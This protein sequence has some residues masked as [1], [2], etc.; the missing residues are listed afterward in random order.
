[1]DPVTAQVMMTLPSCPIVAPSLPF[2]SAG[3][4]R[5]AP[6]GAYSAP[7]AASLAFRLAIQ[8]CQFS[9]G[10]GARPVL[11][12]A[13]ETSTRSDTTHV[14]RQRSTFGPEYHRDAG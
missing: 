5:G 10:D 3:A 14:R 13:P 8:T 11:A 1:M 7:A 9:L 12:C 4:Y 2:Y 6:G